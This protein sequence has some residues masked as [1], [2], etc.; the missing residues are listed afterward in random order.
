MARFQDQ[1][2]ETVYLFN[3]ERPTREFLWI[4]GICA[5]MVVATELSS[6]VDGWCLHWLALNPDDVFAKGRLWQLFT[7]LFLHG[8]IGH[9][10]GNMIFFYIFGVP[11]AAAWRPRQFVAFFIFCGLVGNLCFWGWQAI[12]G[13]SIPSLGA[14]GAIFGLTIAYGMLFGDRTILFFGMI[15][16]KAWLLVSIFLGLELITLCAGGGF[17][18]ANGGIGTLAHLGGAVAGAAWLKFIWWRLERQ[19]G[20]ATARA[21]LKSRLGGLEVMDG[22]DEKRR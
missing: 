6:T 11:V 8:G 13:N 5:I 2:G 15:P 9:F 1:T 18:G 16:M 21:P 7:S 19:A 22:R 20:T 4:V 12:A 10:A 3:L 17:L 14:S